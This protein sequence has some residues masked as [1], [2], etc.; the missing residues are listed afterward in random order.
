MIQAARWGASG[1]VRDSSTRAPLFARI[2]VDNPLRWD[3]YAGANLGYFHKPLAP[4][5][6]TLTAHAQGYLPKTVSGVVV[7][8]GGCATADFDLVPDTTGNVYVEET[9]WLN[10]G[11]PNKVMPT[12]SIFALGAPDGRYFSLGRE[13]DVCLSAGRG[14]MTE[15]SD[16]SD[17]VP[18]PTV[19]LSGWIHNVP[20]NDITIFDGDSV[21]DG[22]W[23]YAGNDWAGP[24]TGLGHANGTHTFDIGAAGLDS[25]RY[26]RIVCDSTALASDPK[27]GLDL[28]AVA[29]TAPHSPVRRPVYADT[30]SL[31]VFGPNPVRRLLSVALPPVSRDLKIIDISGRTVKCYPTG[32][33]PRQY[34]IDLGRPD[35]PP[36]ST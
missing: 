30:F 2:S 10:D 12:T 25:A 11:D 4:G 35:S 8:A 32:G 23:L 26:L 20:G 28:D 6:Y 7:P 33:N 19:R 16:I 1:T 17:R 13:G 15:M 18:I 3:C 27:A 24:W 31:P 22:Y 14:D 36:V 21:A 9:V 34:T 5:T 29:Y